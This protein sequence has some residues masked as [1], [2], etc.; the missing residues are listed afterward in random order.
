MAARRESSAAD[1]TDDLSLVDALA[2]PDDVAAGVVVARSHIP[3]TDV[4]VVDHQPLAITGVVV[5]LRDATRTGSP[6]WCAT[7]GAQV[8]A[9]V[10]FPVAEHRVKAH[11]ECGGNSSRHRIGKAM[12]G[13]RHGGASSLT[14]ALDVFGGRV[15]P[16]RVGLLFGRPLALCS[17]FGGLALRRGLRDSRRDAPLDRGPLLDQFGIA[18][19]VLC[20]IGCGGIF[21]GL[22]LAH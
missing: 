13:A 3:A 6:D 7:A 16:P 5:A 20:H 15:R 10:Q 9:I 17:P 19:L 1:V 4:A 18:R 22:P 8:G 11:S 2:Y 12:A 21:R 14:G